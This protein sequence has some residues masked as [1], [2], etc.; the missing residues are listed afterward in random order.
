MFRFL[1]KVGVLIMTSRLFCPIYSLYFLR[2]SRH[3]NKKRK[4]IIIIIVIIIIISFSSLNFSKRG[5]WKSEKLDFSQGTWEFGVFFKNL[6][7]MKWNV[8]VLA[9]I[10]V[11]VLIERLIRHFMWR[12]KRLWKIRVWCCFST[13]YVH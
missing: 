9:E 10:M 5:Q 13:Y 4:E 6:H 2:L 1:K 11:D 3:R 7:E 12:G 8:V